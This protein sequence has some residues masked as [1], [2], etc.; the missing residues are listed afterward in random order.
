MQRAVGILRTRA[1]EWQIAPDKIGAAGFS[2]DRHLAASLAINHHKRSYKP[3]DAS[4]ETSCRPDFAV[5]LYPAYLTDP[6]ASRERD[7]KLH[8]ERISATATPPTLISVTHPDKFTIGS[9]E[10]CLALMEAKVDVE[11]HVYPDGSHG[12]AV[13]KYP[14]GE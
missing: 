4:D 11:L 13:E 7:T 12:G 3:V 10:F 8:Y 6:I 9:V 14:F 2:A 5:L 1:S